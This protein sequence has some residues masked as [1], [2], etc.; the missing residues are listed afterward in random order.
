M[1]F[2][3]LFNIVDDKTQS[4]I[5]NLSSGYIEVPYLIEEIIKLLEDEHPL[6]DFILEINK[7]HLCSLIEMYF[8]DCWELYAEDIP[9]DKLL[10]YGKIEVYKV[11]AYNGIRYATEKEVKQGIKGLIPEYIYPAGEGAY[12]TLCLL[13]WSFT[14]R[15]YYLRQSGVNVDFKYEGGKLM[16]SFYEIIQ[17]S[18]ADL[19]NMIRFVSIEENVNSAV[20]KFKKFQKTNG[21]K[22]ATYER[23][24]ID[25]DV[26]VKQLL[27][28]IYDFFPRSS[29]VPEYRKAL[30][31][32]IKHRSG[33]MLSPLE[34][35]ELRS[36]YDKFAMDSTMTLTKKAN[37]SQAEKLKNLCNTI[38]EG[39]SVGKIS[40]KHFAFV[41]IPTLAKYN[42]SKCSPKQYSYLEEAMAI[43]NGTKVDTKNPKPET[44][45]ANTTEIVSEDD[46]DS[47]LSSISNMIGQG[48]FG[49]E[50]DD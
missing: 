36:I 1:S 8:T 17:N 42:Y 23:D 29:I 19:Q 2:T 22:Y 33:K 4:L 43:I 50:D 47:S 32:V 28:N 15:N 18:F 31:M 16:T 35:S 24:E 5:K 41:I 38:L 20:K 26:S 39:K 30:A 46:I 27:L 48:L 44:K 10:N 12:K 34:V 11:N 45:A 7:K 21:Y 13:Y 6:S 25:E 40:E 9:F 3:K 14:G 37:L 49:D